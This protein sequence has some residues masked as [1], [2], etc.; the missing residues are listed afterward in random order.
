MRQHLCELGKLSSNIK[1]HGAAK[2]GKNVGNITKR[3]NN[4][5]KNGGIGSW[6]DPSWYDQNRALLAEPLSHPV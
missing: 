2:E 3:Q 5:A 1:I 6:Y 4:A